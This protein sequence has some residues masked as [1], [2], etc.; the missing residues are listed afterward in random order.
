[1]TPKSSDHTSP[2]EAKGPEWLRVPNAVQQFGI[3]K[4]KLYQLAKEGRIRSASIRDQGQS[5]GTR[6]FHAASIRK[7]IE[8]NIVT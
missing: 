2:I 8:Q 5:K 1:M 4:S 7:L 6:L 3:S